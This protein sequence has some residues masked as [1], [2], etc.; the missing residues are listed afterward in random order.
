MRH[1]FLLL[2]FVLQGCLCLPAQISL[3]RVFSHHMVLQRNGSIPV[4]GTAPKATQVVVEFANSRVVAQA[5]ELGKWMV[6]LPEHSAGGPYDL[7]VYDLNDQSSKIVFNDV[8]IGDVWLASGQSNMEWQVQQAKDADLEIPNANH[9]AIRFFFVPHEK[10]LKPE[11][12]IKSGSWKICDS[13]N[14]K[15]ASAVAYYFSRELQADLNVPIGILQTT[16]GGTPIEAW[17]SRDM[18]LSSPITRQ[19]VMDNDT[20]TPS[21]FVKDSLDLIAFWDIVYQIKN[22]AD[23]TIPLITYDDTKW[24]ELDMPKI[25]TDWGIA[26]YEGIV[27]LRKSV[28]LPPSFEGT[29]L[30]INLGHPEM[31]Y[32]LYFNGVE[33]CKTIWNANLSHS[34]PIPKSLV[35]K[36]ENIIAVRL[37]TLWGGGGFNAPADDM[38]L[39]NG[40]A[41]VGLTGTWKYQKDLEPPI[42]KIYNY[43]YYPSYVF[44]AMIHPVLPYGLKGF[45][46]YQGEANDTAAYHYRTLLPMLI[47][48]WRT[49][50]QQGDLPFL[51]VQL[52]NYKKQHPQPTESEWAELREAQALTLSVPNTGMACIIDLGDENNIHPINKQDVGHRLALVAKKTAYGMGSVA[53]GPQFSGFSIKG[54]CVHIHF[55][56]SSSSLAIRGAN[57]LK[58]FAIAGSDQ[59]FHWATARI[60]GNDV[61]VCSEKVEN[62][63]AVRYNWADNPDGNLINAEGLPAIPFRTDKWK[64]ITEN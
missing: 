28:T 51:Y 27:W 54:N 1:H 10:S 24:G 18:L 61:I 48:D 33:I 57:A 46:W 43:H 16:W 60:Q 19:R 37:A 17:T 29:D 11:S 8:L 40:S 25:M 45:I 38:F 4:W 31:N 55:N 53:S 34:Y 58:G 12:D 56:A 9:S 26:P 42:P 6:Q 64:G 14:V 3:P 39:T 41:R 52:P 36:G 22:D 5:D 20:L 21:H 23:K 7:T 49:C 35:K 2:L 62:P 15:T 30:T 63:V 13:S 32:S 44:N 59:T 47:S 50:W